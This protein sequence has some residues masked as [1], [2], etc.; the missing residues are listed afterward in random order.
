MPPRR[1]IRRRRYTEHADPGGL[2]HRYAILIL[3]AAGG[4]VFAAGVTARNLAVYAVALCIIIFA[5]IWLYLAAS[6][7]WDL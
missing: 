6:R 3:F 1:R 5:T 2:R 7:D 4:G